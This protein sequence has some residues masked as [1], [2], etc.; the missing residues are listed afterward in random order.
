MGSVAPSARPKGQ[1]DE[2]ALA[3]QVV[4][5]GL[6]DGGV[7][8]RAPD[9]RRRLAVSP[10]PAVTSCNEGE[11]RGAPRVLVDR[12]VG[13]APIDRKPQALPER[14]VFLLGLLADLQARLD[15]GL[16]P[17]LLRRVTPWRFSTRRSVGRP[18]S[19]KPIG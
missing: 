2:L 19:S 12:A 6:G 9:G 1:G 3:L 13:V 11:L 4:Q 7:A 10:A 17:D 5:L 15:E 14:P 18:L 16:A 8:F